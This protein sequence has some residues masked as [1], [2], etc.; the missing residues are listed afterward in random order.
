MKR[1]NLAL[2]GVYIYLCINDSG[3][4]TPIM[5]VQGIAYIVIAVTANSGLQTWDS[6]V[7]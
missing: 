5:K 7:Q 2:A 6:F 3:P 1:I 4:V